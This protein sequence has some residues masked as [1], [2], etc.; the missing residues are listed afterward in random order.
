MHHIPRTLL[1]FSLVFTLIMLSALSGGPPVQTTGAPQIGSMAEEA[2][3]AKAGCHVGSPV[4]SE[5]KLEILGLPATYVPGMEYPLI[6][7]LTSNPS[8]T[9]PRWGFELTN[10]RLSD[11]IGSG[12]LIGAGLNLNLVNQRTYISQ[13]VSHLYMGQ[14]DSVEWQVTWT[15]PDPPEGLIGF[16]AAGT[17][18]NGNFSAQGDLTYTIAETTQNGLVPVR[19]VTWGQLKSQ[20]H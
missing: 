19:R 18:S 12:T 15:A 2:T 5:G 16:Y 8:A 20:V 7:R 13:N 11:G 3:C 14:L 1:L 17:A 4:N 9:T 6:I 10:A